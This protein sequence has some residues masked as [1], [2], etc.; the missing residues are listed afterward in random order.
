MKHLDPLGTV[1]LIVL[2]LV[3]GLA[4]LSK[5]ME[6]V[7]GWLAVIAL[8]WA[9]GVTDAFRRPW[10]FKFVFLLFTAVIFTTVKVL[11][12]IRWVAHRTQGRDVP[13]R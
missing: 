6:S 3:L 7:A 8:W 1:A 5:R 11:Q 10:D 2:V 9:L 13:P 12:L 4:A